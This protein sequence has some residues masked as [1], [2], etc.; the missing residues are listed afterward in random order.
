MGWAYYKTGDLPQARTYLE[1]AYEAL[2][3]DDVAAHLGEVLFKMGLKDEAKAMWQEGLNL[4]GESY[5]KSKNAKQSIL[6]ETMKRFG[7]PIVP[8]TKAAQPEGQ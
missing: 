2:P 3:T 4:M 5:F 7:V 1:Q 6:H 8:A